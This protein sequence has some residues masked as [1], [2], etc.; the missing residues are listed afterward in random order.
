MTFEDVEVGQVYR[1]LQ[2]TT[3]LCLFRRDYFDTGWVHWLVLDEPR[4]RDDVWSRTTQFRDGDVIRE[5]YMRDRVARWL[6]M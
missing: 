4:S 3:C 5:Q 1:S 2:G 6:K